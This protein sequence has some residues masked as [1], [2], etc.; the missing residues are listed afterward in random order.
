[1]GSGAVTLN[2]R[3]SNLEV[4]N[5]LDVDIV[6][7]FKLMS[8]KDS[9]GIL[10]ERLLKVEYSEAEFI[11]A[12]RATTN[13]FKYIHDEYRKAELTYILISQSFNNTRNNFRNG[14]SQRKY[15]DEL[16]LHL[17]YVYERLQGVRV[18]NMNGID[19]MENIKYNTCAFAFLD[20]PYRHELRGEG[21]NKVY[22][23]ELP[24]KEQVRLLTT[25]RDAKCKIMLCGYHSDDGHDLYDEYLL[26]YG[27]KHYK[28]A[29]LVKACQ[30]TEMKDI[31][32]E[33]I[34][35][36]YELPDCSKYYINLKTCEL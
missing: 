9:G 20:P 29:E 33:W 35:V 6:R 3:R 26:P 4:V 27:W 31:A 19:L 21:A 7:L 15:T 34:W 12:K 23:C 5:D 18:L 28:L 32:E 8:D 14:M 1:M 24:Y 16:R 11:R 22:K 36:N 10:L 30:T 25:I 2:K 13:N 17:P